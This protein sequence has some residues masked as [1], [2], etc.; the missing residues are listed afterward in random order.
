MTSLFGRLFRCRPRPDRRPEEDFFTEALVGVLQ[1]SERLSRDFVGW[2]IC[3]TV[4]RVRLETQRSAGADGRI[5]I[6][7]DA[8]NGGEARHVVAMENKIGAPEGD[9][10]LSGYSAYLQRFDQAETRTLVYATMHERKAR[11]PSPEGPPVRFRPVFWFEVAD[12][13]RRWVDARR[14]N[15]DDGGVFFAR[16]LLELMEQWGM[17]M[18]L[19]AGDLAAATAYRRTVEGRLLQILEEVKGACELAGA[20][21]NPWAHE[22]QFLHYRSPWLDDQKDMYVLFGF[23][24][25][26]DDAEW[27]VERLRL[28][29]AYVAAAGSRELSHGGPLSNWTE[30]PAAWP[31]DYLLV[32]Q[33][34]SLDVRGDSL[35]EQYLDFFRNA[36]SELCE[37]VGKGN[38]G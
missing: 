2:L 10:Q 35:H 28:P 34:A 17:A 19:N 16:E 27:S 6:W 37:A 3:Q 15:P 1:A 36:I 31:E 33:L 5:D 14:W 29:S 12:W 22:R 9:E 20:P 13:L 24:F 8:R 38:S 32:R 4:D 11:P 30:P 18:T 26:R 7:I 21:G 25:Q 23:D